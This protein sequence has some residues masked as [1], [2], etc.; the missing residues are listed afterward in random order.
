MLFK[1]DQRKNSL[2]IKKHGISF[3]LAASIFDDPLHL[4]ILDKRN[5]QEERWITMGRA[6]TDKILIVAHTYQEV[7][8]HEMIRIISARQATGKEKKQYEEGI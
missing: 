3:E 2:N 7:E 8:R 1:W 4:S 5:H 6:I